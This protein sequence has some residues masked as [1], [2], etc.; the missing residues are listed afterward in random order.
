MFVLVLFVILFGVRC[1]KFSEY[2]FGFIVSIV[3]EFV[4]K[5]LVFLVVGLYVC[6]VLFD[7]LVVLYDKVYELNID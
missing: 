7:S 6:F 3:F 1:L 5:L 2:N 4:V